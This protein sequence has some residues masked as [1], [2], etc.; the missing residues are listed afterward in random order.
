MKTIVFLT[1]ISLFGITIQL[2]EWVQMTKKNP[3]VYFE[4]LKKDALKRLQK[5][6]STKLYV[7][8]ACFQQ[9]VSMSMNYKSISVSWDHLNNDTKLYTI[10]YVSQPCGSQNFEECTKVT[11]EDYNEENFENYLP[12]HSYKFGK[13]N[14]A[15]M[16]YIGSPLTITDMDVMKMK[17]S[18]TST[19][20]NTFIVD[21][22]LDKKTRRLFVVTEH[23]DKTF[24]VYGEL[25]KN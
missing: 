22:E 14:K 10:S 12:V 6:N 5:L 18:L 7:V 23:T 25:V 4:D 16:Q 24:E 17:R 8:A 13:I 11:S 3:R 20:S 15:V 2:G 19:S 1:L 9:M 21:A